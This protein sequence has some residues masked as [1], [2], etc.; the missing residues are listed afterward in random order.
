MMDY[1]FVAPVVR[2]QQLLASRSSKPHYVYS[3]AHRSAN[4]LNPRWQGEL[5][6][7]SLGELIT[8]VGG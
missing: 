4:R 3:F 7:F 1:V 6:P 8:N 5:L 2:E